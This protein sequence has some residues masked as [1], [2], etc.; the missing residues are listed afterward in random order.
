M[1]VAAPMVAPSP[2]W[3]GSPPGEVERVKRARAGRGGRSQRGARSPDGSYAGPCN[4][5]RRFGMTVNVILL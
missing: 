1:P 4:Y 3:W 5:S 2:S